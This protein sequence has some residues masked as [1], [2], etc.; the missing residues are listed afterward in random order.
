VFEVASQIVGEQGGDYGLGEIATD[1]R[2]EHF[3][4]VADTALALAGLL[5]RAAAECDTAH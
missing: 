1:Q 2:V 4:L 5:E 3:L